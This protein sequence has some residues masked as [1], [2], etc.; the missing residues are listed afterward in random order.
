MFSFYGPVWYLDLTTSFPNSKERAVCGFVKNTADILTF[1]IL[2]RDCKILHGSVIRSANHP[3]TQDTRVKFGQEIQEELQKEVN[4]EE[5]MQQLFNWEL[6]N[7]TLDQT[8]NCLAKP[9]SVSTRTRS[10]T[11]LNQDSTAVLEVD[12]MPLLLT[13]QEADCN[14]DNQEEDKC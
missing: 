1:K 2:T 10:Q 12:K 3:K 11:V 13:Q 7:A 14:S 8:N 9:D 6:Q 4:N 5:T